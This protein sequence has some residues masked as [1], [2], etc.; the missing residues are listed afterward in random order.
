VDFFRARKKAPSKG[1]VVDN[2]LRRWASEVLASS[3]HVNQVNT[4]ERNQAA[5]QVRSSA[6]SGQ[7]RL[8]VLSLKKKTCSMTY[9]K[10]QKLVSLA[11]Q[12]KGMVDAKS[13]GGESALHLLSKKGGDHAKSEH[14]G[15]SGWARTHVLKAIIQHFLGEACV[16]NVGRGQ[17]EKT[18][19][20]A[21]IEKRGR[22]RLVDGGKGE[23]K[24]LQRGP[25]KTR[26]DLTI[27]SGGKREFSF[28]AT[29]SMERG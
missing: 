26:P 11:D 3:F 5:D 6:P 27:T 23:G 13:Q 25:P 7:Q 17:E 12:K 9:A 10:S 16:S 24:Q 4:G 14:L 1:I 22:M 8:D 21:L 28:Y 2:R 29:R 20:R 19:R 15:G 18:R